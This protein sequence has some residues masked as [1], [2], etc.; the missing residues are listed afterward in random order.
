MVAEDNPFVG[1]L[2][3]VAVAQALGGSGALIVERH[4][5]RGDEFARRSGSR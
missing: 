5:A 2:E 1:G 3:I 4:H